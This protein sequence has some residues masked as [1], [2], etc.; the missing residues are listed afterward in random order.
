MSIKSTKAN[1]SKKI[2]IE[3]AQFNLEIREAGYSGAVHGLQ[4]QSSLQSWLSFK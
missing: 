3:L 2:R 4:R 1:P